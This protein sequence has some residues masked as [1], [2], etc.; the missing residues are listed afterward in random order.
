[1]ESSVGINLI[2]AVDRERVK[3]DMSDRMFSIQLLDISP[4]YWCLLK[5]GKRPPTL[6]IL[7][8]ILQKLPQVTP[9]VMAY[10]MHQGDDGD[11]QNSLKI[12]GVKNNRTYKDVCP[13]PNNPKK[14]SK[15]AK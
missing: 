13:A 7:K 2:E 4:S 12:S 5:A 10:I 6:N 3:R 15:N 8:I 14:P 11:L 1:M 9:E